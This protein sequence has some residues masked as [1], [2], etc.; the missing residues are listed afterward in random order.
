MDEKPRQS[1]LEGHCRAG[2]HGAVGP[3]GP[4]IHLIERRPRAIA[5]IY[6]AH[7]G[8]ELAQALEGLGMSAEAVPGMAC[9]G[10]ALRLLWNGPGQWLVVSD[11]LAPPAM[12][13]ALGDALGETGACLVDLSHA[14]TT[15]RVS[16]PAVREFLCKSCPLDIQIMRIDACATSLMGPFTVLLHCVQA[17]CFDLYVYRSFG[18]SFWEMLA[19]EAAEFGYRTG[20]ATA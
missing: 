1:A 20:D 12:I 4:G 6:G 13:K 8:P 18:L 7:G 3:G 19:D 11:T 10:E 5:Q 9:H 2:E 17:E 16:G 15:V 14:R